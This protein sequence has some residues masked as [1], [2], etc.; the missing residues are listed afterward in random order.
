[1]S[2]CDL[3]IHHVPTAIMYL[4][5][6]ILCIDTY[7]SHTA[8]CVKYIYIMA[9][10]TGN[11]HAGSDSGHQVEIRA[12]G[13]SRT[14]PLPDLP[15]NDY[16]EHKGDLW[17]I[18]LHNDFHFYG[19]ITQGNIDWIALEENSND[20]WQIES[21]VTFLRDDYGQYALATLDM[22]VNRWIDGNGH[23]THTRFV[24]NKVI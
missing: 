21:V 23:Y 13:Q 10:T 24:L 3:P 1:M 4:V 20:G 2:V 14:A 18:D 19:C 17:K 16:L 7:I 22:E 8:R 9:F 12:N 11:N 6:G 5:P 15:G